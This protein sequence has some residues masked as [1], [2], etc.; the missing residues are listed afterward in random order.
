MR[1]AMAA[2][3]GGDVCAII[4]QERTPGCIFGAAFVDMRD[5]GPS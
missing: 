5:R 2:G 1:R 3:S 4:I